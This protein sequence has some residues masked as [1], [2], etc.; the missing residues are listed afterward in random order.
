M[1]PESRNHKFQA[2]NGAVHTRFPS[3]KN[4]LVVLKLYQLGLEDDAG[5]HILMCCAETIGHWQLALCLMADHAAVMSGGEKIHIG[6]MEV[7]F[8]N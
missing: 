4:V 8:E 3:S 2:M 5:L 1:S 6:S 7:V